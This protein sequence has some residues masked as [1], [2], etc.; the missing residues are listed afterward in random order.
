M[1]SPTDSTRHGLLQRVGQYLWP[2]ELNRASLPRFRR[3]MNLLSNLAFSRFIF[4]SQLRMSSVQ[5]LRIPA[6]HGEIP[7]RCYH[8]TSA[9]QNR[10]L[11]FFHGGGF[12]SGNLRSHDGLS[13]Y[14]AE[15]TGYNIIAV[16][17]R[18]APEYKFPIPAEDCYDALCWI[19]AHAAELG[20]APDQLAIGG[21]SAG[22]NLAAVAC[23]MARDLN[24]P[25]FR[26]QVLAF[27]VTDGRMQQPSYSYEHPAPF[28]NS[29][30]MH[31]FID[32]YA[33]NT[34]DIQNP[35]FS[36]LLADDLQ[37]LPP[38]LVITAENDPLR[39]EG[40][41]YAQK[42]KDVGPTQHLHYENMPHAFLSMGRRYPEAAQAVAE[43]K[44]FLDEQYQ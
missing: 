20:T 33:G 38:A 30:D 7:L 19:T 12:V 43:I 26:A 10:T 5:N 3:K 2:T 40:R 34:A 23:L 42:L 29:A 9:A 4:D 8:P 22:G 41:A 37:N 15:Q 32:C 36:P 1:T 35:Y 31:F 39:D 14:L 44:R 6:R 13:R 24:G 11:I 25:D 18:L 27:P 28:L 16:Q 17:Y 21:G